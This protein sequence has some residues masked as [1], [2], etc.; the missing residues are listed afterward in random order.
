MSDIRFPHKKRLTPF[1]LFVLLVSMKTNNTFVQEL[2]NQAAVAIAAGDAEE[3][4][5]LGALVERARKAQATMA[6]LENELATISNEAHHGVTNASPRALEA[7]ADMSGGQL[8]VEINWPALG[9]R[10]PPVVIQER[11]GKKA[12][13]RFV[14]ELRAAY[15]DGVLGKLTTLRVSRG[16]L[17]SQQP[18]VDFRNP[19]R[20]YLYNHAPV[21]GTPY[22]LL[23]H[24]SNAEKLE[25]MRSAV[26][27][28]GLDSSKFRF[29]S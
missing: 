21:S 28:L 12:L 2:M 18:R 23:T 27:H 10:R 24:S 20:G 9:V 25:I 29:D 22:S 26:T 7:E 1:V 14:E 11:S 4:V 13:V 16:P 17:V 19:R 8:R 6:A 15:G 5:R 3:M